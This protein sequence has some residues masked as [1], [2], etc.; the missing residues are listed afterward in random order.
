[1]P[2]PSRRRCRAQI[3]PVLGERV[4]I[5]RHRDPR[6]ARLVRRQFTATASG[7]L[8]ASGTASATGTDIQANI[9]GTLGDVS[10][11]SPMV[12]MPVG[13]ASISR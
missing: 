2:M 6:S 1:M 13:G 12:G 4:T 8:S 3:R 7:A 10:V 5:L 9:E 11:L